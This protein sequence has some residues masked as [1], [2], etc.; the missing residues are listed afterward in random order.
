MDLHRRERVRYI[1]NKDNESLQYSTVLYYIIN[2]RHTVTRKRKPNCGV[3][4]FENG[5]TPLQ[6]PHLSWKSLGVTA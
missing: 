6:G 1:T 2:M 3:L 5:T 4:S